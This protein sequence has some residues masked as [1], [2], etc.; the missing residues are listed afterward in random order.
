MFRK[1][2]VKP[3]PVYINKEV[4]LIFLYYFKV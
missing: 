3:E 4:A 2:F 1:K